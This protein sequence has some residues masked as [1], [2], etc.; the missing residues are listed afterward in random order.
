MNSIWNSRL[1][2][3]ATNNAVQL[4][5]LYF[6]KYSLLQILLVETETLWTTL[7]FS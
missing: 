2:R 5:E 7:L 3:Y 6:S 1:D 4:T